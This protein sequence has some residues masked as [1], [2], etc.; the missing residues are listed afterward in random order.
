[1]SRSVVFLQAGALALVIATCS[2]RP[3]ARVHIAE[4]R[5]GDTVTTAD[6]RVV[7]EAQ[8]IEIVPATEKR[9]GTGHHHLFL[10]T[11]VTPLGEKI[12]QGVTGI[13]HL[14]RGQ[15]DFTFT[16]VAPGSHRLIA[17]VADADHVPIQPPV[18]DTMH[19]VTQR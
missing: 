2:R 6:V 18:V 5:D 9:P 19:F 3:E 10:D 8:G 17:V 4:P 14:G 15:S 7:L 13:I 16:D 11:D 1:M 12:P